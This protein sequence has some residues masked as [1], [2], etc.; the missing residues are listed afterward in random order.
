M[1]RFYGFLLTLSLLGPSAYASIETSK[2]KSQAEI[3]ITTFNHQLRTTLQANIEL[4]GLKRGLA[5]CNSV[6]KN[7]AVQNTTGGWTLARTSLKV[8]NPKNT[9]SPWEK[10]QLETFAA[11]FDNGKDIQDLKVERLTSLGPNR[12]LYKYMKGIRAEAVCLNCHG[13]NLSDDVKGHLKKQFPNDLAVG[14]KIGDLMGAFTLEKVV[15]V[16]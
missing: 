10:S 1:S 16:K 15:T 6:A 2:L 5:G 14:Y 13:S 9:P 7:M 3:K 4:G 11:S 8:R 12:V